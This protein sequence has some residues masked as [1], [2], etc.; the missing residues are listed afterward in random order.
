MT[1]LR[2]FG[3]KPGDLWLSQWLPGKLQSQGPEKYE[4]HCQDTPPAISGSI[5]TLWSDEN[6]FCMETKTKKYF[7]QQLGTVTSP[8][9]QHSAILEI[10]PWTQNVY[11]LCQLGH[12]AELSAFKSERKSTNKTHSC[13]EAYTEECTHFA[14]RG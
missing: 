2:Y 3:W 5:V 13:V 7:I 1:P 6:T 4:K 9:L 10:N 8:L 14:S 12:K 11:T